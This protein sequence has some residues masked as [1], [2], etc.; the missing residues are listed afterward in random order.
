ME[1]VMENLMVFEGNEV[2]VLEFNGKVLFNPKHVAEI[3][4]IKNVRDNISKMNSNQVIKL[5]NSDVGKTDFRKLN[6]RGENFLTESGVYKL[7][8]RSNK[9]EAERFTDWVVDEVIPSIRKN[10]GYILEQ[11]ILEER[12]LLARAVVLYE[13]IVKENKTKIQQLE[14]QAQNYRLLMDTKGNIDFADFVKVTKL[15]E[16]RNTFM[17]RLRREKILMKNSTTPRQNY[18]ER[19]YFEVVQRIA[20]NGHSIVKTTITKKGQDWL[21]KKCNQW[22]L[23]ANDLQQV[24]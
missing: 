16:G 8:M 22:K 20:T 2:E 19:G 3:L 21:I 24:N 9:P 18:I 23:I 14:P 10:K 7:I 13:S 11:E 4:G 17:G 1:N 6:N 12:E 15:S 5:T